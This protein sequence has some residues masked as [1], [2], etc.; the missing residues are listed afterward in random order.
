MKN[1]FIKT[2]WWLKKVYPN[3]T[4]DIPAKEKIVY[5]SFDDGPHEVATP[6]VLDELKKAGATATFFC[7]GK[8]VVAQPAIYRRILDEGHSVGNHTHNHLNGWK[9]SNRIYLNDVAEA[10]KYIDSDLFRPPYGRISRFQASALANALKKPSV[11]VVMWDVLSADFDTTLSGEDCLKNV[12]LNIK[13]GSIVI[14]HD[15]QKAWERL[16]YLLPRLMV[17][18]TGQ[19]YKIKKL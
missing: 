19:G 16:E 12:V 10:G 14:M 7:I 18:L 13:P 11:K 9:T 2:P 1:Y 17:Y 4:W 8:N 6:F 5:L 15:S 3:Y